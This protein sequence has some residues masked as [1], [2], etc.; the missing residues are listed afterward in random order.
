MYDDMSEK[1]HI[2]ID[3]G[4]NP[5]VALR[6]VA[7]VVSKGRVGKNGT[8]YCYVTLFP[9]DIRVVTKEYRKSD[10][11]AVYSERYLLKHKQQWKTKS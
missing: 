2:T 5:E 11:F 10:C 1:I 7:E 9:D 3:D 4:I 8:M 6:H